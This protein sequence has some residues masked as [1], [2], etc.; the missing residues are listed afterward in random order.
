[1]RIKDIDER[2]LPDVVLLETSSS[3]MQMYFRD[4]LRGKVGA[5]RDTIFNIETNKDLEQIKEVRGIIPPF[6]TKWFAYINLDKVTSRDLAKTIE[7]SPTVLF[8]VTA[9]KYRDYKAFKDKFKH[10]SII[11]YDYYIN[12]L[13]AN[14]FVYL[15]D[16]LCKDTLSSGLFTFIRQSYSADVETCMQIL[17]S[18]SEGVNLKT[19]KDVTDRFGIGGLTIE[20]YLLNLLALETSASERGMK[21]RMKN[22]VKAGTELAQVFGYSTLHNYLLKTLKDFIA[23]KELIVSGV[24]YKHIDENA[25]ANLAK[26]NRYIY[27]I[28]D[29]PMSKFLLL[30]QALMPRWSSELEFFRCLYSY[31]RSLYD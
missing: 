5:T 14:D 22:R 20:S 30:Y 17:K 3:L 12:F 26:Y 29:I 7:S 24:V 9:S 18:L 16:V 15:Y 10:S 23:I 31:E 19:K 13:R 4:K 1:M 8:F 11:V 21:T 28:T 2:G 6:G 25:D 27:K